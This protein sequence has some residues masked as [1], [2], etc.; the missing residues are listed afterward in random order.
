M[1]RILLIHYNFYPEPTGI[2]KYNGE[3]IQ[4]FVDQGYDCTVITSYPYYPF[5][6]VQ[7][8]YHSRRFWYSTEEVNSE[9]SNGK[10]RIIR[11]PQYVPSNPSG[12]KRVL[13]D[14]SFFVSAALPLIGFL[15]K[16]KF[17]LVIT[18]APPFPVGLLAVFYKKI[19]KAKLLYHTQDMQIEAARDLN[20]I[21][22]KWLIRV[23][24][25]IEKYIY[26]QSE[27]VSSISA[28]MVRKISEKAK[29]DVY[30][31][32]NWADTRVFYPLKNR[33]DLRRDFGYQ[34]SDVIVLY[35]GSIGEK[36]G[37]ESIIHAANHLR[38]VKILK[39]IVCGSGPY[40]AQLQR[41]AEK[42]SLDNLQFLPI[43]PFE[44][45][46]QFL[47]LADLHLIIQK[48]S[49]SD[50]VMPSK[51]TTILSVGGLSLI[52]ANKD[53]GLYSLVKDHD[54]G[55]LVDA[56]NQAAL[57]EGILKAVNEDFVYLRNNARKY[58]ENYL[59]ID[60][61]MASLE[62]LISVADG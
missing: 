17:D 61:V 30:L 35:S 40:R 45:F 46:N 1:K 21:K 56:E 26:D 50:L 22:S 62:E 33:L 4:W 12:L 47:N 10:L 7:E 59:S 51:L 24:L 27:I 41:L 31:L 5:W 16:K 44:K 6:K 48:S 20:M 34:T 28:E 29:K 37:L 57:N 52:T 9:H 38:E 14:L 49:A 18:V 3:M 39:F 60:S 53:S 25:K 32:P 8:P 58:A 55:I 23:L 19:R 42:L 13:L 36:Q 43:Q 2:G 54:L 15:T 11:C